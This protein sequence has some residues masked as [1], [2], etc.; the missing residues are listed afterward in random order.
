M[1]TVQ[2]HS[3]HY[4]S[5]SIPQN[6][7]PPTDTYRSSQYVRFYSDHNHRLIV[8]EDAVLGIFHLWGIPDSKS[9]PPVHRSTISEDHLKFPRRTEQFEQVIFSNQRLALV[10]WSYLF[11]F[12]D[13]DGMEGPSNRVDGDAVK[14]F[15][16]TDGTLILVDVLRLP[17]EKGTPCSK[18]SLWKRVSINAGN[19]RYSFCYH[20][21]ADELTEDSDNP[22]AEDLV[23]VGDLLPP[24]E[25]I[26]SDGWDGVLRTVMFNPDAPTDELY[27][28]HTT[29][30]STIFHLIK[31]SNFASGKRPTVEQIALNMVSTDHRDTLAL[32]A[33]SFDP[34]GRDDIRPS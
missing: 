1:S 23:S 34:Y 17:R 18:I 11:L 6:P 9:N 16:S 29:H 12:R 2:L 5:H 33:S 25:N 10:G 20:T 27:A 21:V 15:S 28:V 31:F 19:K 4:V 3:I 22:L 13:S 14:T 7:A 32:R 26:P 24:T 30:P 8:S